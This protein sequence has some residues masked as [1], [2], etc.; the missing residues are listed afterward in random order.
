MNFWKMPGHLKKFFKVGRIV[1]FLAILPIY[2]TRLLPFWTQLDGGKW[3]DVDGKTR[4]GFVNKLLDLLESTDKDKRLRA[5]RSLLYLLQGVFRECDLE[6]DQI[7]WT[8]RNV[9][10][11]IESGALSSVLSLL[12]LEVRY[13]WV[14]FCLFSVL[15]FDANPRFILEIGREIWVRRRQIQLQTVA[16]LK[17]KQPRFW[18]ARIFALFCL[19]FTFLWKPFVMVASLSGQMYQFP[20]LR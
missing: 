4:R 2:L 5:A 13:E 14:F 15:C 7:T 8:R 1:L 18:V 12:L 11:C 9:Y 16:I 3:V 19:Y 17:N 6:E 10:L 20:L